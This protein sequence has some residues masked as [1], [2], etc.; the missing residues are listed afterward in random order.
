MRKRTVV[1][2]PRIGPGLSKFL[3]EIPTDVLCTSDPVLCR[4][5]ENRTRAICS[6]S[7]R[8]TPIL[9][10][11]TKPDPHAD[12]L[13]VYYAPVTKTIPR[14]YNNWNS[15]LTVG[16]FFVIDKLFPN[17]FLKYKMQEYTLE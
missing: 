4:G 5:A 1:G 3:M 16:Y 2:A 12:V 15:I 9:R 10:P 14:H 7:R 11:D 13:P 8:T 17:T 6:Q